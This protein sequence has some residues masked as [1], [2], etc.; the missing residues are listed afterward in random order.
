MVQASSAFL[1]LQTAAG[2]LLQAVEMF[3]VRGFWLLSVFQYL[4]GLFFCQIDAQNVADIAGLVTTLSNLR[5]MLQGPLQN[6]ESCPL[7]L[8]ERVQTLSRSIF[9][10][11]LC[12]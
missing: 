1:P 4:S 11:L 3:E 8:H 10:A 12:R 2:G 9:F 6:A 7:A 5:D